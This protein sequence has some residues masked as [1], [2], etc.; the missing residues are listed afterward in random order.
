[1]TSTLIAYLPSRTASAPFGLYQIILLGDRCTR[2]WTTCP[3][4]IH[5]SG[6]AGSGPCDL[7]IASPAPSSLQHRVTTC[8]RLIQYLGTVWTFARQIPFMP[9]SAKAL[10]SFT[11]HCYS[12]CSLQP[13]A[14]IVFH[15]VK[16]LP[17]V[18]KFFNG[19]VLTVWLIVF[20]RPQSHDEVDWNLAVVDN[21]RFQHCSWSQKLTTSLLSTMQLYRQ[22]KSSR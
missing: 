19:H 9:N 6:T 15:L 4:S 22:V 16:W 12:C 7:L 11:S 5:E 18:I 14:C 10:H 2:V 1:M 3:G 13:V 17:D 8:A 21:S 20:Y